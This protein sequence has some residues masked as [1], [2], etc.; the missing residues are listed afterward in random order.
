MN[1]L[2][3]RLADVD[4]SVCVCLQTSN[5]MNPPRRRENKEA[6]DRKPVVKPTAVRQRAALGNI[7]NKA[8]PAARTDAAKV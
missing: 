8:A 3:I 4:Q 6:M 7:S 2:Q 5:L 1:E